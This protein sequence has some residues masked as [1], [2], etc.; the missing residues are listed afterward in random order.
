[1]SDPGGARAGEDDPTRPVDED[2]TRTARGPGPGVDAGVLAPGS[3]VGSYTVESLIG[4]GG[5]GAVYRAAQASPAR[6]VALKLMRPGLTSSK[7]LRRFEL[8]AEV[9]GRLSHHGIAAIYEAGIH[10]DPRLG[11]APY[12]AMEFVDGPTLGEHARREDLGTRERL[13]LF[14]RI[15]DAVHHAHSRGI[16]HRDLKPSNI[17]VSYDEQAGEWTP[18]ILDFGVARATDADIATTTMHTDVGQIVGTIPYM[19]PEQVMG[20]PEEIDTRSDVYALGVVLYELLA[21][22]LPYDIGRAM[23]AEAARV[24]VHDDPTRLS[25]IDT[26]LRG[27]IET[28]VAKALEKARE[29]RYQSALDLGSDI[30]RYLHDEPISARPPSTWYQAKKFAKRNTALV[31]GIIAAFVALIVGL[32]GTTYGLIEANTQRALANKRTNEAIEAQRDAEEARDDAQRAREQEAQRADELEQVAA[33]QSE[34]FRS[35]NPPGVGASIR[36]GILEN[37][38]S[39]A[40]KR[41][42]DP[43]AARAAIESMG[44]ELAGVDFTGVA[45]HAINTHIIDLTERA[46]EDQFPEK[47]LIRARLLETLGVSAGDLGSHR[48]G[49]EL[50]DRSLGLY[51]SE[52]GPDHPDTIEAEGRVG[53]SMLAMEDIQNA[54]PRIEAALVS[55]EKVRGPDARETLVW[56]HNHAQALMQ[57]GRYNDAIQAFART[58]E[59]WEAAGGDNTHGIHQNLSQMGSAM[60]SAGRTDAA[61]ETLERAYEIGVELYGHDHPNVLSTMSVLAMTLKDK[62]E[63]GRALEIEERVLEYTSRLMGEEH[64]HALTAAH[65]L[66][67][68]YAQS[69]RYDRAETL[70]LRALEGNRRVQGPDHPDTLSALGSI[71]MLKQVRGDSAGAGP[72]FKEAYEGYARS[73]GADHPRAMRWANN[74]AMW[75]RV[76]G[77]TDEARPIFEELIEN[78]TRVL[79][80]AHPQTLAALYNL[81]EMLASTGHHE[82][83]EPVLLRCYEGFAAISALGDPTL[84]RI[85]ATIEKLY[86]SWHEAD[87]EGGHDAELAEFRA[88]VA[89]PKSEP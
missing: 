78:R 11:R 65:N 43:D 20:D 51:T 59:G 24:I 58:L 6:T 53:W 72:Y 21:G 12:F 37:Y 48:R 16:I 27:D 66:A 2:A 38:E 67:V 54:L 34:Q 22:R 87:P 41:A 18:K 47:P 76:S 35:L 80:P 13:A 84:A 30:R 63:L 70:F 71:G 44:D 88:G 86:E 52:L 15:C 14:A 55:S 45:M 77:R 33:F 31:S 49:R 23:I 81:G 73:V 68:S 10:E 28:I 26:R 60:H 82:S 39:L 89:Q 8:E 40:T 69:G 85:V 75:L 19:S 57:T 17:L 50:L 29:R 61:L 79:G 9:L 7:A 64:P 25:S 3:V 36:E 4:R 46:I 62:G 1:M 5:M 42:E 56:R 32:I 83:A 74:Y